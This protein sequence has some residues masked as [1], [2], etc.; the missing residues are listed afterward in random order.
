MLMTHYMMSDVAGIFGVLASLAV[1]ISCLGLLGMATY[2]AETRR[3][4]VSVRKVLGSSV[5]Q[6]IVLL[7]KGFMTLLAVAIVIAVPIAFFINNMW[8]QSFAS[9]VSITPWILLVNILV[10]FGLNL[11][12]VFS[13][14]WK[15]SVANPAKSL[16]TE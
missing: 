16:R 8:L 10:M 5:L 15:V 12:I 6:V 2:T 11:L 4:E 7:S 3:K 14:A 9:R 13:Q 1:V